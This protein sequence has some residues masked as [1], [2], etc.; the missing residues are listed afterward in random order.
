MEKPRHTIRRATQR[1]RTTRALDITM[2][3]QACCN[4]CPLV[5]LLLLC[6]ASLAQYLSTLLAL[7]KETRRLFRRTYH[8]YFASSWSRSWYWCGQCQVSTMTASAICTIFRRRGNG[9]H[10]LATLEC[11]LRCRRHRQQQQHNDKP[12]RSCDRSRKSFPR[13][14]PKALPERAGQ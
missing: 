8:N 2:I 5:L 7:H 13:V 1:G 10:L 9:M 4:Q 3:N 12:Q 6:F 11:M 14:K